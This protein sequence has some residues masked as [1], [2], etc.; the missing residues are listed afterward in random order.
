MAKVKC[1][2]C[3]NENNKFCT[4]KKVKVHINKKR[5][6][7]GYI[8]DSSKLK[9]K[10]EIPLI[11]IG[12]AEQQ[13]ARQKAKMKLKDLRKLDKEKTEDKTA[14]KTMLNVPDTKHPLTGDLSR[15]TTTASNGT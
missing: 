2:V 11:Q 10:Q 12:Y 4:I 8:Y 14:Q 6:C 9:I 5:K 13:I 3:L 7:D 1:S 15:F